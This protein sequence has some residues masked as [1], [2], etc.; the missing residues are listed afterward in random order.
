MD[1]KLYVEG[2]GKG[3]HKRATIKLQQGFDSFLKE[4]KDAARAKKISFKIL[5]AGNT[6]ST[7]DDFIR[8]VENA[9][10]NLNLLLVD[11]DEPVAET[12]TAR[13][14]LQ[15]KYK[16]WNLHT[17]TDEQC[18]LMAQ[19]MESWFLADVDALKNFYGKDFKESVIPKNKNVETIAKETVESALTAATA[20]TQ[21]A[22]YHKIEHGA[23][24]L[25]LVDSNKVRAAAPHCN[26]LFRIIIK[27]FE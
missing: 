9:P 26:K 8:S 22:E 6:Q 10:Q 3:S 2:G 16:S 18:H 15:N 20:K 13:A 5:P 24:L 1:I 14:F 27:S 19:I 7:Y 23:K 17:V 4:L 12:Q 25:E 21:K 11:S